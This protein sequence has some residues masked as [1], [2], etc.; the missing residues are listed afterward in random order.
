MC[1]ANIA[2]SRSQASSSL[3]SASS[4]SDYVTSPVFNRVLFASYTPSQEIEIPKSSSSIKTAVVD[5][6][7]DLIE[8]P[9]SVP[10][11]PNTTPPYQRLTKALQCDPRCGHEVTVGRRIGLY[12]FCGDIGR[13][14]FSKVKLAVHQLTRGKSMH[15]CLYVRLMLNKLS[16]SQPTSHV[17]SN[18]GF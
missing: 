16:P 14:N 18:G 9:A 4:S 11:C 2:S 15:I 12:R 1:C 13:G 3:P 17:A 5:T 7:G 10:K 6:H 8:P